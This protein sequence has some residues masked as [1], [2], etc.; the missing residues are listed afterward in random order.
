MCGR[1]HLES[2]RR[3]RLNRLFS[4]RL[5]SGIDWIEIVWIRVVWIGFVWIARI[6]DAWIVRIYSR[7]DAIGCSRIISMAAISIRFLCA[8]TISFTMRGSRWGSQWEGSCVHREVAAYESLL[9]IVALNRRWIAA[10]N[11]LG[12][13]SPISKQTEG[14]S[15]FIG[16]RSPINAISFLFKCFRCESGPTIDRWNLS[17]PVSY[18]VRVGW[19]ES[20]GESQLVKVCYLVRASYLVRVLRVSCR[21]LLAESS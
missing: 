15:F 1:I 18:L 7:L 3:S 21:E 17:T 2:D 19:W 13:F 14:N 4:N 11:H 12:S 8:S 10:L 20:V 5:I 16:R 9:W 6:R